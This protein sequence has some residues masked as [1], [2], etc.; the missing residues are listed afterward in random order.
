MFIYLSLGR[1]SGLRIKKYGDIIIY[2]FYYSGK[3]IFVK[4][5][6][7]KKNS[8]LR[9]KYTRTRLFKKLN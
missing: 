2:E 7:F 5:K 3:Q 8:K 6:T 4:A 1:S 9:I